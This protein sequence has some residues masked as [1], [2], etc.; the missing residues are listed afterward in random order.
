MALRFQI[1]LE[2]GN[3]AGF[4]SGEGKSSE[5][6]EKNLSEQGQ[7]Q[8]QPQPRATL[9]GGE[10]PHLCTIPAPPLKTLVCSLASIWSATSHFTVCCTQTT[11]LTSHRLWFWGPCNPWPHLSFSHPR[12]VTYMSFDANVTIVISNPLFYL[13]F[14]LLFISSSHFI[15]LNFSFE[16]LK[17]GHSSDIVSF[18]YILWKIYK[19]TK[20]QNK[21]RLWKLSVLATKTKMPFNI[22]SPRWFWWNYFFQIHVI[23]PET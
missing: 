21:M 7:E 22:H 16:K 8:Q 12:Y 20:E 13:F 4:W 2:F 5:Y 15:H 19:Q 18:C 10:C 11:E 9:V 6:L 3:V 1:E 23:L 17:S 14:Q